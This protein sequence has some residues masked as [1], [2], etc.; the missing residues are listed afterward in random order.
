MNK[1]ITICILISTIC[2]YAQKPTHKSDSQL[3]ADLRTTW[4]QTLANK[5]LEKS[6]A[7]YTDDAIFYS[8]D[9]NNAVGKAGITKLYQQVMKM[10]NSQCILH[11]IGT[12]IA[13]NMAYDSG[14]Y[15]EDMLDNTTHKKLKLKG[16]YL[17][18][19]QKQQDGAWKI[20][21]IMWTA[22]K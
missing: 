6:V 8:P 17:M 19:L 10:Y 1:L 4:A 12:Q 3:I 21:R 2:S 22:G 15:D 11:S 20:S 16:S 9:G 18:T 14:S 13:G 5:Q 7:L